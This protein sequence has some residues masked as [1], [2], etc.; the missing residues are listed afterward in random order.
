M[1]V[2]R[3]H[4]EHPL[5]GE[6]ER[7]HL[8][9]DRERFHHEHA[10]DGEQQNFLLDDNRDGAEGTAEGER[11]DVAHEHFRRM[12]VVPEKTE[13]GSDQRTAKDDQFAGVGNFGDVE[14]VGEARIAGEV[15]EHGKRGGRNQDAA[16]GQAVEA[17]GEIDGVGT[18]HDNQYQKHQQRDKGQWPDVGMAV[19]RGDYQIRMQAFEKRNA[20]LR[21]IGA[22][23]LQAE[24]HDADDETGEHLVAKF[25]ARS[26]AQVSFAD[27]FVVVVDETDRAEGDGGP[28]G[29]KHVGVAQIGPE[30]SGDHDG[31]DDQHTAHGGGSG[32][33]LVRF[34]AFFADVLLHLQ[35]AQAL[36]DPGAHEQRK[37][38]GGNAGDGGAHG[39]VAENVERAEVR[40]QQ[41]VEEVVEH[42][43]EPLGWRVGAT[44]AV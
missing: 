35:R 2:Q 19:K 31:G 40:P 37:Q 8:D 41:E 15:S 11:A 30:Q 26:E 34:G 29:E 21:G 32:F 39:D 18:A 38:Q 43:R 23:F 22:V 7:A 5:A 17:V 3:S 14:I 16:D 4:P 27:D 9:D 42:Q 1:M 36:D 20:E 10:A 6:L 33:F 24:E 28:D 44:F 13:R 12:R 25:R